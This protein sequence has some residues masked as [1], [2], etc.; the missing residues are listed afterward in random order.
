[1]EISSKLPSIILIHGNG[2]ST[3]SALWFPYLKEEFNKLGFNVIA[4]DFPDSELA[5]EKYWMPFLKD[6]LKADENSIIIG[7]SSGAI[8][9]MKFAETNKIFGSVLVGGYYTDLNMDSEKVSGYFDKE[10]QWN[11]IKENQNFIVQVS[12]TNDPWINKS[13]PRFVHKMLNSEYYEYEEGGHFGGDYVKETFPE[14]VAIVKKMLN[15][16]ES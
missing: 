9:A 14:I 3:V 7:H 8:L 13:E 15:L 10:W 1:M 11:E 2:G 6:E 12:A 4:R 5:R 16:T